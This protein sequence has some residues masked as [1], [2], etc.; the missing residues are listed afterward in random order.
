MSDRWVRVD[1][2]VRILGREV[3]I[4]IAADLLLAVDL[5]VAIL[6]LLWLLWL[7]GDGCGHAVPMRPGTT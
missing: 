1:V 2:P 5:A 6:W 4:M 3:V 7:C